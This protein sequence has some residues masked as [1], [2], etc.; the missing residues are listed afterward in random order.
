[1]DSVEDSAKPAGQNDRGEDTIMGT[2]DESK[3]PNVPGPTVGPSTSKRKRSKEPTD[4][5]DARNPPK[6]KWGGWK[7][8]T[9]STELMS[10]D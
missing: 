3:A 2:T 1:M 8:Y 4:K 6:K 5:D 7:P 9:N 10:H